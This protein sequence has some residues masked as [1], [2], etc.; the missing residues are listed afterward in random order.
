MVWSASTQSVAAPI[1]KV[2]IISLIGDVITIDTY[3]RRVGTGIDTNHQDILPVKSPVFDH[4]AL[5]AAEE[6]VAKLIPGASISALVVP[7]PGSD[8]DPNRIL[9]DGKVSPSSA[10]LAALHQNGFTHLLAITKYRALA[11][12]ELAGGT[13]GSGRLQGIGFYIDNDFGTSRSDTGEPAKGF[14]APYVY[15]RLDLI[16]LASLELLR[17]ETITTSSVRSAARNKTGS[18]PWGAM[19]PEEKISMLREFIKEHIS[20]AVPLLFRSK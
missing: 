17:E 12:L 14:I 19:T 7:S 8:A 1:D 15:I 2:A 4:T 13:V 3:R 18:D 9:L 11:R 10:L 20:A 16:D 6:A 5:L